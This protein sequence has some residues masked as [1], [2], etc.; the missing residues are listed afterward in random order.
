[1]NKALALIIMTASIASCTP[2]ERGPGAATTGGIQGP[3]TGFTTASGGRLIGEL[4]EQPGQCY[5]L[6]RHGRRYI[7]DCPHG[8]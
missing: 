1:M 8:R 4:A 6:D 2:A 3:A 7:D 5:Y